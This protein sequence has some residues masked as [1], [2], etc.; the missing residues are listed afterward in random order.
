MS[1]V[2][3]IFKKI[4]FTNN[5]N[6][7]KIIICKTMSN[8]KSIREL[9]RYAFENTKDENYQIYIKDKLL[10]ISSN[11]SNYKQDQLREDI[12]LLNKRIN[13]H[14][15]HKRQYK[16]SPDR[17]VFY[18]FIEQSPSKDL[19]HSHIIL[20]VPEFLKDKIDQI[21]DEVERHLPLFY[22]KDLTPPR[23]EKTKHTVK[24]TTRDPKI[25]RNY[26]TK[27]ISKFNDI[28]DVF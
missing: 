9:F 4:K 10:H 22:N 23:Y 15:I 28:F 2:Q 11:Q 21:R 19:T 13:Q 12:R 14:F 26:S 18:C 5:N 1:K 8:I 24:L 25:V 3:M 17:I 16:K 7:E 20:R 6:I 27:T